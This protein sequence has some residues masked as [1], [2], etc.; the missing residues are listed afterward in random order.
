MADGRA[1]TGVCCAVGDV[2]VLLEKDDS[3]CFERWAAY[4]E[5]SITPKADWTHYDGSVTVTYSP[6]ELINPQVQRVGERGYFDCKHPR[7]CSRRRSFRTA[8]CT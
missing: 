7:H 3:S 8:S 2:A 5:K 1:R 6:L 4:R